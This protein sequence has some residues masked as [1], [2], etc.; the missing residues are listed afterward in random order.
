VNSGATVSAIFSEPVDP[1][2]V[3]AETFELRD[4]LS[5]LV[6]AVI[7]Y[8]GA[9][10]TAVLTPNGPLTPTST[11]TATVKTGVKDFAGNATASDLS[12]SFTT[13]AA[14]PPVSLWGATSAPA[15]LDSN[16]PNAV[17]LGVKFRTDVAGFATAIRF[18]K[19]PADN[20]VHR[21]NLWRGDGTLLSSVDVSGETASGWQH[22]TLPTPVAI[23]PNTIYIASYH[24][25]AGRYPFSGG[26]FESSGVDSGVLHAPSSPSVAG[27]G[28]YVYG[29]GGFPSNT[30]NATNYWVDVVFQP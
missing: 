7:N 8:T 18:Y 27:N 17:E 13:A 25:T 26:Y 12:W 10:Q 19:G 30:F 2:T 14:P 9:S 6:P 29:A 5:I 16:D 28:V 3:G 15:N 20:G 22:V 24:T 1:S 23:A 11:Y 21:V 4:A